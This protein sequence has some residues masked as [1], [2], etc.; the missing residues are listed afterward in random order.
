MCFEDCNNKEIEALS[1]YILKH[2]AKA[3]IEILVKVRNIEEMIV[4]LVDYSFEINLISK[5]LYK[6]KMWLIY[7]E[8]GWIIQIIKNLQ[9]SYSIIL[10]QP[11]ILIIGMETKVLDDNLAYTQ[12]YK[13]KWKKE[14]LISNYAS[15]SWKKSRYIGK[16]SIV[17]K[18]WRI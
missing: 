17:K 2:W 4:V 10:K 16:E 15:K 3:T 13:K 8:H 9:T 1:H 5:D 18:Y 11:L 14:N 6:K 7:I 12:I